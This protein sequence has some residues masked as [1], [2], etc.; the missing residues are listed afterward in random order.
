MPRLIFLLLLSV[1]GGCDDAVSDDL[2]LPVD[3]SASVVDHWDEPNACKDH[4]RDGEET[5]IDCGGSFCPPCGA[6]KKCGRARDCQ[7][8]LCVNLVCASPPTVEM[9]AA[10]GP[11]MSLTEDM[12]GAVDSAVSAD[13]HGG[14]MKS[15]PSD[16]PAVSTPH[17]SG[18]DH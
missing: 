14:D 4:R 3:L 10:D 13:L 16:M 8:G 11:P 17:D 1:V 5:D 12:A 18:G 6:G 2:A 7:S 15:P 9:G